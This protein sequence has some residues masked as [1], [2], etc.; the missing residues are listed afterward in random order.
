MRTAAGCSR[1]SPRLPEYYPTRTET[2][3]LRSHADAVAASVP[4]GGVLI[5]FGSELSLNTEILLERLSRLGAY[6][7]IDVSQSALVAARRRLTARSPHIDIR[8]IVV[9]FSN[10]VAFDANRGIT[11]A[12]CLCC[13]RVGT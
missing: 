10:P 6:V 4:A 7:Q 3:I 13:L 8:R 9:D 2:A 12:A 11:S 5:E 1:G